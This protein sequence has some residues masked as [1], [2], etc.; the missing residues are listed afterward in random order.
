M[1]ATHNKRDVAFVKKMLER[2]ERCCSNRVKIGQ[3]MGMNDGGEEIV[4]YVPYGDLKNAIP[5]LSRR[6]I[7]NRSMLRYLL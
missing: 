2:Y 4:E 3:L 7:E 1:I 6:L 5:Y